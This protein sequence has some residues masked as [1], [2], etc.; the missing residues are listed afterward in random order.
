MSPASPSSRQSSNGGSTT[1]NS[2]QHYQQ[3]T[4]HTPT[5]HHQTDG[6]QDWNQN[7]N[8][9]QNEIFNQSDRI[10]LNTRLKTM[11]LNKNEK[12]QQQQ[13]S[14]GHFLSYSHQHLP[15]QQQSHSNDN[16][17][18]IDNIKTNANEKLVEAGDDGG[19]K[20]NDSWKSSVLKQEHDEIKN[21]EYFEQKHH[22]PEKS[23]GDQEEGIDY[24]TT[25]KPPERRLEQKHVDPQLSND[26]YN[27][28]MGNQQQVYQSSGD[29]KSNLPKQ[30][31]AME[32]ESEKQS[33]SYH[34][35]HEYQQHQNMV[36]NIKKEPGDEFVAGNIKFEG[37][38]KNYQ[39]FIRYADFCDA[40]QPQYE[41]HQK[42]AQ[43]QQDYIQSQGYYNNYPYQSYAH[44]QSQSH[45]QNYQQ[46]ISQQAAYQQH[47]H[48]HSSSLTNFEQQIPLHTYPIPKHPASSKLG[49]T[50]LPSSGIKTEPMP[51]DPPGSYPFSSENMPE[52][53][54]NNAGQYQRPNNEA[55]V[56]NNLIPPIGEV[57]YSEF[58]NLFKILMTLIICV[59][60]KYS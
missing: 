5:S 31:K 55:L 12:D 34:S 33:Y 52:M 20:M 30:E 17:N 25:Q 38:E 10:N 16:I 15:E 21:R 13:T 46:F 37:Y 32:I 39:N 48:H 49:E 36:N 47:G 3:T 9:N 42:P 53:N 8:G 19:F 24:K 18:N 26:S 40:Q 57:K 60:K 44:Q 51:S 1:P 58:K 11:I 14:T 23:K 28:S 6:Q 59:G 2:N 22:L 54:K 27:S 41:N 29:G 4:M 35:A 7:W 45:S 56:D 50:I 43:Y